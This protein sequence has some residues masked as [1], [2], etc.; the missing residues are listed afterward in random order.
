VKLAAEWMSK[1]PNVIFAA[2][3]DGLGNDIVMV[4]FHRNYSMF[5]DFIRSYVMDWGKI[6][7]GAESFIVSLGSGYK[8]KHL[9]L[10]Y[11]ADDVP[12]KKQ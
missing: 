3:G 2:E 9:D 11:L 10:K 4:S 8:M 7:S 12:E 5:A 1:H 6:L